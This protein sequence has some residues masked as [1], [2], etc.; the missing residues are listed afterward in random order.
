VSS[1]VAFS[2]LHLLLWVRHPPKSLSN[3]GAQFISSMAAP[4][5]IDTPKTTR[6]APPTSS[7][8][9]H[10]A[11]Y[12]KQPPLKPLVPDPPTPVSAWR[13]DTVDPSVTL[14]SDVSS[15]HRAVQRCEALSLTVFLQWTVATRCPRRTTCGG[16]SFK[17]RT[18]EEI[19]KLPNKV[20][21]PVPYEPSTP[22]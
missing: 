1:A 10:F 11:V 21:P 15:P 2:C 14:P 17:R 5:S 22:V 4:H 6:L 16:K 12:G 19:G 7:S 9:T 20:Q 18:H 3:C 8:W 13:L